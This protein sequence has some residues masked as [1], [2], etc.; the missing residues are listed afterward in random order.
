LDGHRGERIKAY[1]CSKSKR[2]RNRDRGY[3]DI[4]LRGRNED[5]VFIFEDYKVVRE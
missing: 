3:G 1:I 4:L 5:N 2:D